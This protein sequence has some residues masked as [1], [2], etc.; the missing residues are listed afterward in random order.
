MRTY[1]RAPVYKGRGGERL[2]LV[3]NDAEKVLE[4]PVLL[5]VVIGSAFEGRALH[6]VRQIV[7]D[8][9]DR[10]ARAIS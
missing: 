4:T 9:D 6:F 8:R 3:T 5:D 7:A 10:S 2:V 1:D